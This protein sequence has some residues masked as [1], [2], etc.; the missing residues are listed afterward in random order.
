MVNKD[1]IKKE[2]FKTT[3]LGILIVM[4]VIQ[5]AMLWLGDVSSHNFLNKNTLAMSVIRPSNIW[6]LNPGASNMGGAS[7][8]AYHID[9]TMETT[10]REYDRLIMELEELLM[11]SQ[12]SIEVQEIDSIPWSRLFEYPGIM[13]E[14]PVAVSPYELTGGKREQAQ[15]KNCDKVLLQSGSKFEKSIII[16]FINTVEDKMYAAEF[17]GNFNEFSKL[18]QFFSS[19]EMTANVTQFQPSSTSNVKDFING[20]VFMPIASDSA[21]IEYDILQMYNPIATEIKEAVME[22]ESYV[23][24]LFI[25]PLIK[26]VEAKQDGSIVFSEAKKS[27]VIYRPEGV[28]EYLNLETKTNGKTTLLSGYNEAIR[29]MQQSGVIPDSLRSHMYLSNVTQNGD[30]FTYYFDMTYGGYQVH[31]TPKVKKQLGIE[32]LVKIVVKGNQITSATVCILEIEPQIESGRI[33]QDELDS[34]YVDPINSALE[35]IT[36]GGYSSIVFD[37]AQAMYLVTGI[38][39]NVYMTRGVKFNDKWY[40]P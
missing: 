1:M 7:V 28:I 19:K 10:R 14:Y 16:Y 26:D 29:F 22:L 27:I 33:K 5:T 9:G 21:P 13:Y 4:C 11:S 39:N 8:L 24:G 18:H 15:I 2:Y 6:V 23:N 38:A 30:E 36:A 3:V 17:K 20:N 40:Y 37:D 34:D 32:S 31:L 35:S 25:N 12:E